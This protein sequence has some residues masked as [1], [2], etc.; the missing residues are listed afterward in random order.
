MRCHLCHETVF[1]AG[2]GRGRATRRLGPPEFLLNCI[3]LDCSSE[4]QRPLQF[5]NSR[6]NTRTVLI[7]SYLRPRDIELPAIPTVGPFIFL[8]IK[9]H[10][11][12]QLSL[13]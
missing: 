3:A 10:R 7:N 2:E 5:R 9:V 4:I 11:H 1:E 12:A 8:F 6:F 13:L